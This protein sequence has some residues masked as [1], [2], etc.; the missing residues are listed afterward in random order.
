MDKC[1]LLQNREVTTVEVSYKKLWKIL[2]DK[3][4]KKK[5]LQ[6]AAGISWASV[7]KLSKGETVSMDVL[8]KVCKALNCNIGDVVDLIPEDENRE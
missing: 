4:M 7:T 1:V 8:M 2:I 3:D 6:A 5:D